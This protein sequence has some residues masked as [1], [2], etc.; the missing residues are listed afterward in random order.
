M[1]VGCFTRLQS[2]VI[3]CYFIILKKT[4]GTEG[5]GFVCLLLMTIMSVALAVGCRLC[6]IGLHLQTKY[7]HY[8]KQRIG[9]WGGGA[10]GW[11][12][13]SVSI[14]CGD[15]RPLESNSISTL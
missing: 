6:Y 9:G 15:M 13:C 1:I 4:E 14:H 2:N 10:W 11:G 12:S 7:I 5:F 8:V 3:R